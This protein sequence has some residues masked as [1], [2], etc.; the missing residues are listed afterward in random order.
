MA[1]FA[2]SRRDTF[3][4][5]YLN[6]VW[7]HVEN[8]LRKRRNTFSVNP[9][10]GGLGIFLHD[11][12]GLEDDPLLRKMTFRIEPQSAFP[13][14]AGQV[15]AS[16]GSGISTKGFKTIIVMLTPKQWTAFQKYPNNLHSLIRD[17]FIHELAH[18]IDWDRHPKV[19]TTGKAAETGDTTTYYNHPAEVNAY[20]L[21]YMAAIS[22][23]I[24]TN[25]VLKDKI[26]TG[27]RKE[28]MA[29]AKVMR[30][31][32]PSWREFFNNLTPENEV[33][34]QKRLYSFWKDHFPGAV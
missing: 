4:V 29:F 8:A 22:R 6:S 16:G 10:S 20:L 27:G 25:E 2:E 1:Y 17:R 11:I 15:N 32:D 12:D 19:G 13:K 28:F 33:R 31:G 14:L 34:V 18:H 30:N 21:E 26:T 9:N 7:S 23:M 24:N 3:D 5:A